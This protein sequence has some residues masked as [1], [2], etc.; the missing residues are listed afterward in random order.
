MSH[1]AARAVSM[2]AVSACPQNPMMGILEV[3]ESPF[4]F[5]ITS[6]AFRFRGAKSTITA[7]NSPAGSKTAP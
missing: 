7:E 6:A 4:I 3:S 1:P 2:R 5:L